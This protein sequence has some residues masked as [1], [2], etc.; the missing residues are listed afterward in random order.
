MRE[1]NNIEHKRIRALIDIFIPDYIKEYSDE[2]IDLIDCYEIGFTFANDLLE[3]QKID[4]RFSPWGDGSSVIFDS[5][6]TDVLQNLLK[7]NLNKEM[8][9]Y[10]QTYLN[11][12]E[13]FRAHFILQEKSLESISPPE[14][15]FGRSGIPKHLICQHFSSKLPKH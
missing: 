7:A 1:L 6:Y 2:K 15:P 11:A 13:V 10:C 4:P 8:N 14:R 3:N 5:Y 9:D 12:L